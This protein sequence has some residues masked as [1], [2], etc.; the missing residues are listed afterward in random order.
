MKNFLF[1]IVF[2]FCMSTTLGYT[3]TN[4]NHT[5]NSASK[6][7]RIKEKCFAA[8]T[9]IYFRVLNDVCNKK[10]EG[11][12]LRMIAAGQIYIL[13][14][15]YSITMLDY[16]FAKCKIYVSDLNVSVYVSTEFIEYR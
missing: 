4:Y 11:T 9:E 13:K 10:D 15:Q 14:P 5:E 12:L 16:G 7:C 2:L 6:I 3:S 1:F 8:T